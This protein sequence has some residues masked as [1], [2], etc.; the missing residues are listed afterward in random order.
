MTSK[1]WQELKSQL[2]LHEGLRFKPYSDTVGKLTIG[3]GRNL[4]DV[5]IRKDEAMQM[6]ENDLEEC[7]HDMEKFAWFNHLD[8]VRQRAVID[9]RFNMGL[10]GLKTFK[11]FLTAMENGDYTAA[12]KELRESKWFT[13]VAFRGP[14]VVKMIEKGAPVE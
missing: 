9:L 8:E 14:R 5:G 4:T 10:N 7:I 12:G 13:Q 11:K 6:L 1:S 3:V 2:I